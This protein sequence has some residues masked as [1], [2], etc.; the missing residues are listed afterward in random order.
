MGRNNR[1]RYIVNRAFQFRFIGTLIL[2]VVAALLIFTA[3]TSGYYWVRSMTGDNVFKEYITLHKQVTETRQVERD[4]ELVEEEYMVSRDFPGRKRWE[5]IIPALLVNNLIIIII[6]LV[7]GVFSSHR[8]AGPIYRIKTDIDK[9]LAGDKDVRIVLRRKDS[10]KEI[11]DSFN[12]L[13]ERIR[14]LEKS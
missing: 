13:I 1:K 7:I 5:L 14:E 2:T 11:A 3:L 12:L 8:I 4:G 9:V 10:L 6:I